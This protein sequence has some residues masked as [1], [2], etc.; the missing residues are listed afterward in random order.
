[1]PATH[2]LSTVIAFVLLL[3]VVAGLSPGCATNRATMGPEPPRIAMRNGTRVDFRQM[4][5]IEVKR[6]EKEP[7]RM[8]HIAPLAASALI[9]LDRASDVPLPAR[10]KVCWT[11]ARGDEFEREISLKEPLVEATGHPDELLVFEVIPGP[12]ARA[13]LMRE[14]ELLS[15][16]RW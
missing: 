5:V 9:I 7:A 16:P 11:D 8:G 3:V 1:M 12:V 15:R 14:G 13:F 4:N 2:R 10:A 6:R